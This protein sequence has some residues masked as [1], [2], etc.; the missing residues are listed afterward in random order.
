MRH[1][2]AIAAAGCVLAL[3]GLWAITPVVAY[4]AGASAAGSSAEAA[5]APRPALWRTY[6]MI[7]NLQNLPRTYTCDELWY[8]LH[9][10]LLRL[11]A[12]P[13]SINILP[14]HCSPSP[15]GSLRSPD[16][17][18]G[19]QLPFFLQGVAAKSAPAQ[20]VER[21]IRL[22]P[23]EPDTLHPSDCQ[24]M[25]QISQ[26]ML[27]SLA[28]LPVRIDGQHFDCSAPPRRAADFHVTVTLPVAVKERTVATSAAAPH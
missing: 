6:D 21:T 18:V 27:A 1:L 3:S 9:G 10:I 25:Q 22:S 26:T 4:G 8:E 16:V 12:W 23:G 20:A 14:Y 24:L 11:G 19:F 2:G 7:L 13:Y 5:T 17:Q 15:S 28:S